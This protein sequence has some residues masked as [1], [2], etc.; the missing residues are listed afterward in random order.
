MATT[1]P[2]ILPF[3]PSIP[4]YRVTTTLDDVQYILDVKWST[5]EACW[6]FDLLDDNEDMI[7]SGIKVV[8]GALLGRRSADAR[9]PPG[10]FQARDLTDEGREATLD[11][12]GDRV[13]VE[14]YS[15]EAIAAL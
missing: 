1:E 6:Y 3:K 11:D 7:R 14:Y 8:L 13:I 2:V 10:A 12:M 5:R 4:H 15:P 9:F